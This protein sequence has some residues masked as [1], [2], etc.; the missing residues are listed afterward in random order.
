MLGFSK[1]LYS[2]I[3][4]NVITAERANPPIFV[5][6]IQIL[7]HNVCGTKDSNMTFPETL[8]IYPLMNTA[9]TFNAHVATSHRIEKGKVLDIEILDQ[10]NKPFTHAPVYLKLYISEGQGHEKNQGFFRLGKTTKLVLAEPVSKISLPYMYAFSRLKAF[11]QSG[12]AGFNIYC[13]AT[14]ESREISP[15]YNSHSWHCKYL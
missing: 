9:P 13:T 11:A 15:T 8:A 2:G 1:T 4:G 6:Y 3:L 12:S 14:A 5:S 10:N 7:C